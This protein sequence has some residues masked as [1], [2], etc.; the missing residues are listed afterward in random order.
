M[1]Y[2]D[3]GIEI[4][5]SKELIL[6][7]FRKETHTDLIIP[8]ES[9]HPYK[10]KMAALYAFCYRAYKCLENEKKREIEV[11]RIKKIA[12]NNNYNANVVDRIMEKI[13]T[14]RRAEEIGKKSYM[15]S[16][17]Y[18]GRKTNK[19]IDCFKKYGIDVTIKKCTTVFDKIK[20]NNIEN[21]Q[22]L[23]KSGVYKIKCDV[24]DK[25]YVGETGRKFEHRLADHKRGEGSRTTNSLYAR[26][27]MEENHEFV[28]PLEKYKI[29]NV[30]YDIVKRKLKE[31]LEILKEKRKE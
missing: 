26:H 7:I 23:Q 17:S 21:I 3:L 29:I 5:G 10:Y 8:N 9:H 22:I 12:K 6:D 30:E 11:E 16:I 24:C 1:N 13:S 28:N 31:E 2:L 4:T 25:V 20:N 27:F 14:K 19:I 15:G 18:I